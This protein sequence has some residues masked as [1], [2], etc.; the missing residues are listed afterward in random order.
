LRARTPSRRERRPQGRIGRGPGLRDHQNRVAVSGSEYGHLRATARATLPH[1]HVGADDQRRHVGAPTRPRP[2]LATSGTRRAFFRDMAG[3]AHFIL[4]AA[5]SSLIASGPAHDG[6]L[7]M[8]IRGTIVQAPPVAHSR[9]K[10]S[11]SVFMNENVVGGE[12]DERT[13][14]ADATTNEA[15]QFTAAVLIPPRHS[16]TASE[17]C[18]ADRSWAGNVP[19]QLDSHQHGATG[20]R[21]AEV[22][23][24]YA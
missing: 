24:A 3:Q 15:G 10:V 11:V 7:R 14:F 22:A 5:L 19:A 13:F 16:I 9:V 4:A 18:V 20:E 21:I 23:I 17:V 8:V 12:G 6:R 2:L 1:R